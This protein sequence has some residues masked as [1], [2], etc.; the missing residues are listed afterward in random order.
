MPQHPRAWFD[1]HSLEKDPEL[2]KRI[3]INASRKHPRARS[4]ARHRCHWRT[5]AYVRV[6]GDAADRCVEEEKG[7]AG[8]EE[9]REE[10]WEITTRLTRRDVNLISVARSTRYFHVYSYPAGAFNGRSA[11]IDD[12]RTGATRVCNIPRGEYK[13]RVTAETRGLETPW[14]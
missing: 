1:N 11:F 3:Y 4:L 6:N 12:T 8:E 13:F 9:G 14:N 10:R 7:E 2:D 5:C